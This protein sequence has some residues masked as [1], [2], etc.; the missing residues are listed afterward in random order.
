METYSVMAFTRNSKNP[1]FNGKH[2]VVVDERLSREEAKEKLLEIYNE[3]FERK[4]GFAIDLDDA[5]E[6]SIGHEDG[7][8]C[9]FETIA[10]KG[11]IYY[12]KEIWDNE[13]EAEAETETEP[14]AEIEYYAII[15]RTNGYIAR[16]DGMFNGKTEIVLKDKLT[17]YEAYSIL[18]E[19]Y[20]NYYADEIGYFSTLLDAR[21]VNGVDSYIDSDLQGFE[22][23]SR[24]FSIEM[25]ED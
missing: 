14:E 21:M 19:M 25:M 9:D 18:I 4:R 24:K 3:F 16:R 8:L 17:L 11:V 12:I 22:Y 7:L 1:K 20:N 13:P 2:W 5:Y 15:G 6:Q 10:N 23:D